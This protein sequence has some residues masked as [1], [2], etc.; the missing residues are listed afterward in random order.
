MDEKNIA[1]TIGSVYSVTDFGAKGDGMF[2]NTDAFSSALKTAGDNGG[3]I[4][5]VPTGNYLFKGHITIPL[6]VT[7]QGVF[8]FSPSHQ[9]RVSKTCP[10]S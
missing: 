2:D 1:Q 8:S 7:L 3:G 5:F 10:N 4:V 6:A 9:G